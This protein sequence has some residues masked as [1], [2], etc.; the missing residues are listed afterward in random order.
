MELVLHLY[1]LPKPYITHYASQGPG[2]CI[3]THNYPTTKE[4]LHHQ[5]SLI[6]IERERD[7]IITRL[8]SKP[9]FCNKRNNHHPKQVL[10]KHFHQR[11]LLLKLPLHPTSPKQPDSTL[12]EPPYF[13]TFLPSLLF[14]HT[15]QAHRRPLLRPP[16]RLFGPQKGRPDLV[17]CR[18][19]RLRLHWLR[20]Q[21]GKDLETPGVHRVWAAQDQGLHGGC[22]TGL[23]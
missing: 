17:H 13:T 1:I 8:P 10:K 2:R 19:Q 16:L 7:G 4:T 23:Q 20:Y 11:S 3:Y 21:P 12:P 5:S 22:A 18:V 15:H 9:V 14:S 6:C